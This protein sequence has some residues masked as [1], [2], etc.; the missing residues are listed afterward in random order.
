MLSI[1]NWA[2]IS[3]LGCVMVIVIGN[4]HG[5]ISSNPGREWLHFA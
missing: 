1:G 2:Y 5:D 3:K 4:G